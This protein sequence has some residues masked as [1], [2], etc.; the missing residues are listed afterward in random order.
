VASF[1]E[2]KGYRAF[3]L[4]GGYMA[5][6]RAGYPTERKGSSGAVP[7]KAM[8]PECGEPLETHQSHEAD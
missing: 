4:K 3:A 8:C 2:K 1:L 5:W 6:Y 7:L